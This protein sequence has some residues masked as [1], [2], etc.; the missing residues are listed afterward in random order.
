MQR[1][2]N[3]FIYVYVQKKRDHVVHF[4]LGILSAFWN[5]VK[6]VDFKFSS[7]SDTFIFAQFFETI[8]A[9]RSKPEVDEFLIWEKR[10]KYSG[11]RTW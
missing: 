1:W 3:S 4:I 6:I 8:L 5:K 11:C 9:F 2:W 7:E 10:E